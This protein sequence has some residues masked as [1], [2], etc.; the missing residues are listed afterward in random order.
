[1]SCS[2]ANIAM[3]KYDSL[4]NKFHLRPRVW[5]RFRD[6]IFVL[7]EHGIASLPLFLSYLNSMD[8]TGKINFTMEI[9]GDTGL[10]FLDL[11]L[12]IVEGKIRV[13]VF[14]KPTNSFSYT[15][16]NTCY[17]K[18][19]IS[20]IPKGMTLRLR[21]ICDDDDDDD[22]EVTF[23]KRSLKY[24]NHLIAREHKPS[25]VKG[26]FS[27]FKNKTSA[28]ART[29]QEKQDKVSDVK[30]ITTYNPAL[31]NINKIIQ[32]N[33]TILHT[34]EDMKKLFLRNSLTTIYRREKNFKEI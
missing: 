19:N 11:R 9:A 4:A 21:T 26:K 3:A 5:K 32:N 29:K 31:P 30:L 33:L 23:D 1:M 22:D 17:P 27:E 14:A 24:Q 34:D 2:Y 13:D 25:T 7:W 28:E 12:K 6:D 16:P 8:K 18:K 15:T 20:N 10:E